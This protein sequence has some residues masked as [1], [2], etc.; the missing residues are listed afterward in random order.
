MK[1]DKEKRKKE[2]RYKN[3][4]KI[5]KQSNSHV[6]VFYTLSLT[7]RSY[8]LLRQAWNILLFAPKYTTWKQSRL[9]NELSSYYI[10]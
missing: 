8:S 6:V 5:Y 7:T 9:D 4:S 3:H 1:K 10:G 2:G